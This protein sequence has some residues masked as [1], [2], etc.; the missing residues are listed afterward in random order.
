MRFRVTGRLVVI[1]GRDLVF[2]FRESRFCEEILGFYQDIV[3]LEVDRDLLPILRH[4]ERMKWL[5]DV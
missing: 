1:M 2:C 4:L 5:S 3:A